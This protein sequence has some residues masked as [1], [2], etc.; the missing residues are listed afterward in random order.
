MTKDKFIN[1]IKDN[2][3]KFVFISYRGGMGG[4]TICNHLTQESDYFYNETLMADMLANKEHIFGNFY[5]DIDRIYLQ[6][7]DNENNNRQRFYDWMF[8]DFF[9]NN[10]LYESYT[11]GVNNCFAGVDDFKKYDTIHNWDDWYEKFYQLSDNSKERCIGVNCVFGWDNTHGDSKWDYEWKDVDNE[12]DEILERFAA[13]DKPYLIRMHAISPLMKFMEGAKIIDIFPNEWERYCS[14]LSEGKV[15]CG[16]LITA[17]E[18]KQTIR[19]VCDVYE[20]GNKWWVDMCNEPTKEDGDPQDALMHTHEESNKLEQ[21]LLNYIG[22]DLINDESWTLYFKTLD[23]II[24][25]ERYELNID[26]FKSVVELNIFVHALHMFRSFP[27]MLPYHM[28][29]E[30]LSWDANKG[31]GTKI[32]EPNHRN[33]FWPNAYENNREWYDVINPQLYNF[34]DILDGTFLELFPG[35]DPEPYIKIIT[36]WHNKN[37]KMIESRGITNYLPPYNLDY[38]EWKDKMITFDWGQ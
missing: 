8:A 16:Q 6:K 21:Y 3:H 12:M 7:V 10:S 17:K 34:N 31:W 2:R 36:N 15:F 30:I 23:V 1:F 32:D 27:M 38:N 33:Q 5:M 19:E 37:I 35:I 9:M 18:K 26:S 11:S 28:R 4:E 22:D 29:D 25:P 20:D 24:Y 14:T 13:Q